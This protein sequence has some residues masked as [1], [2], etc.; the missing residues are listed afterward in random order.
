M[1]SILGFKLVVPYKN[2]NFTV[3]KTFDTGH[4]ININYNINYSIIIL[5]IKLYISP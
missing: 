1:K 4:T 5:M 2:L 3:D